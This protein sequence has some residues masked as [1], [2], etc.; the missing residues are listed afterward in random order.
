MAKP[1]RIL[2]IEDSEAERFFL[3]RALGQ[4]CPAAEVF[5][6]SYADVALAHLRDAATQE[7]EIIF[8]DIDIPRMNG[9]AFADAFAAHAAVMRWGTRLWVLSHSID[10]ADRART[11]AHPAIEGFLSKTYLRRDLER[12]LEG[13]GTA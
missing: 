13:G 4:C 12:I 5:E 11:K 7:P 6:F 10:P 9:F 3:R 8:V 2:V 1:R